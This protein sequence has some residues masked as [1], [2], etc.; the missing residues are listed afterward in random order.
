MPSSSRILE[1]ARVRL[2]FPSTCSWYG[3]MG[4]EAMK[5]ALKRKHKQ[6]NNFKRMQ[7]GKC[8]VES[9]PN[10]TFF[11]VGTTLLRLEVM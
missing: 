11:E 10:Y 1:K 7:D 2:R 5:S 4:A 8:I 9:L 6:G 3:R